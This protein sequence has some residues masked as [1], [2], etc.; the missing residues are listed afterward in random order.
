MTAGLGGTGTGLV[1]LAA[2]AADRDG[3]VLHD[4]AVHSVRGE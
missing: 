3:D 2:A 4:D 1:E